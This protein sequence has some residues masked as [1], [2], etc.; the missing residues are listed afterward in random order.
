M[1]A[2]HD[3]RGSRD[4]LKTKTSHVDGVG[5]ANALVRIA[6]YLWLLPRRASQWDV[7]IDGEVMVGGAQHSGPRLA[8]L[9]SSDATSSLIKAVSQKT[10]LHV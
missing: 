7:E 1:L 2:P 5:C 3:P 6:K 10:F 9:Q 4:P 8:T